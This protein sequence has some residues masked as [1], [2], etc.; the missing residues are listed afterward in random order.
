MESLRNKKEINLSNFF[1]KME[2]FWLNCPFEPENS[3]R[4]GST[5]DFIIHFTDDS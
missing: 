2:L 5:S 1:Q 3:W 4:Q